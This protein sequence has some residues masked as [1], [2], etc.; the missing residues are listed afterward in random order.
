MEQPQRILTAI[1][2][3]MDGQP[4][5]TQ[6]LSALVQPEGNTSENAKIDILMG[7]GDLYHRSLANS[8]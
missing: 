6:K 3:W 2:E 7:G 8:G 1:L 4:F 5:L